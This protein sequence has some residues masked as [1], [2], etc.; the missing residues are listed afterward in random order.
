MLVKREIW[1]CVLCICGLLCGCGAGDKPTIAAFNAEKQTL[2]VIVVDAGHGGIDGGAV[3]VDGTVEKHINLA[4]AQKLNAC[5]QAFGFCT[6]MT[7]TADDL[8]SDPTLPTIRQRKRE[9]ILARLSLVE[10]IPNS[11]L[12]SIHQNYYIQARY[13]GA[14]VFYGPGGAGQALAQ[15]L[16]QTLVDRL[17]KDNARR[18]KEVG[19]EIYLLYHATHTAV[20]VE[21]GFLSN[22]QEC[23]LL[24]NEGYQQQLAFAMADAL[25]RFYTQ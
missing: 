14:Q 11:V 1:L 15:T 24:Q 20:M 9:D 5:L 4:I 7:R 17:Q 2:P 18:V 23:S 10:S 12:V 22:A 13:S 8:I 6:V 21:C 3:G 16:Q 19:S 25:L